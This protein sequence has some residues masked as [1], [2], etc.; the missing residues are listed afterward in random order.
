[1]AGPRRRATLVGVG[2]SASRHVVMYAAAAGRFVRSHVGLA[3][4]VVAAFAGALAVT[5]AATP[6]GREPEA[7]A[8]VGSL[9][10]PIEGSAPGAPVPPGSA[11][12]LPT[13]GPAAALPAL[14]APASRSGRAEITRA[15]SARAPAQAAPTP[16]PRRAPAG[17]ASPP[18]GP[19][20]P[21][22]PVAPAPPPE[23]VAPGPPSPDP[24]PGPA[25]AAPAPAPE[26]PPV[27]FD[28]SG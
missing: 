9:A 18:P 20:P 3:V 24:L 5:F 27:E 26:P 11:N 19:A 7:R 6:A 16:S 23:P 1:M 13:L 10:V 22:E 15:R 8:P 14:A 25:P 4:A 21:P 2:A 12:A 28:D 17:S